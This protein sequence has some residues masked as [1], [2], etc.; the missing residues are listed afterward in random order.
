MDKKDGQFSLGCMRP[1]PVSETLPRR[2]IVGKEVERA[3]RED[4]KRAHKR[5]AV[6][7]EG[8]VSHIN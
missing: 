7:V 5:C 3:Q 2:A 6:V 8:V 4:G 1:M